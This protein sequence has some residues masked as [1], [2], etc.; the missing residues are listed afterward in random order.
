MLPF[1]SSVS[2][3]FRALAVMDGPEGALGMGRVQRAGTTRRISFTMR[4]SR[5]M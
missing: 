4:T 1:F 3:A 5:S 2:Y